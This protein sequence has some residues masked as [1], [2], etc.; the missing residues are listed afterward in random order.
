MYVFD[1]LVPLNGQC[2]ENNVMH[3]RLRPILDASQWFHIFLDLQSED[4][5]STEFN[6]EGSN[7]FHVTMS[8]K[9]WHFY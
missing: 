2:H 1:L 4:R 6:S 7:D 9:F 5:N 3:L 8:L